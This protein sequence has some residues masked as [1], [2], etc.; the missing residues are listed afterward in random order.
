MAVAKIRSEKIH[1]MSF[2]KI[3]DTDTDTQN[4]LSTWYRRLIFFYLHFE[5]DIQETEFLSINIVMVVGQPWCAQGRP[6]TSEHFCDP[7]F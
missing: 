7:C 5:I 3:I 1:R 2:R 4:L 6:V